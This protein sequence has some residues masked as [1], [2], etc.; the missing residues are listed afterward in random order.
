MGSLDERVQ[1]VEV[2]MQTVKL[3]TADIRHCGEVHS[4]ITAS[5][6]RIIVLF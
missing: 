5:Y 2:G 3:V 4:H 6:G 1:V